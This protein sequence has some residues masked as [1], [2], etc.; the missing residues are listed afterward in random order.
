MS[1]TDHITTV[2]LTSKQKEWVRNNHPNNFSNLVRQMVD[3]MMH[4]ATPVGYHNAWREKAQKCYPFMQ[5]GYCAICWPAGVPDKVVWMDY[6]KSGS[7]Q[8]SNPNGVI[9][10]VDHT[11]TFEEWEQQRIGSRQRH[12]DEWNSDTSAHE[13]SQEKSGHTISNKRKSKFAW[14]R[15]FW[16]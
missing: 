7:V 12:L 8:G 15:R 5:G 1:K 10:K 11:L 9:Q 6:I 4:N 13:I 14:I 16:R 3:E 2:R